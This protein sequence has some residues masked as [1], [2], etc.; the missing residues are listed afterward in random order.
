M[1]IDF[2]REKMYVQPNRFFKEAFI[3]D[4]SGISLI[5]SGVDLRQFLVQDILE[6]S[7]ASEVGVQV[8]DEILKLNWFP[9]RFYT[10]ASMNNKLQS[11]IGK[12]I[13]LTLKRNGQK[14]KVKFKLR[15]LI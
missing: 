12:T 6:N 2:G 7:P 1:I 5:T 4:R 9:N 11:K 3:Y 10:L 15:E 8:G 13:H 14:I